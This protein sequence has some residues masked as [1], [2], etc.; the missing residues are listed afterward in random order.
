MFDVVSPPPNNP[1]E[2]LNSPSAQERVPPPPR[3]TVLS[4]SSREERTPQPTKERVYFPSVIDRGKIGTTAAAAVVVVVVVVVYSIVFVHPCPPAL[5][6]PSGYGREVNFFFLFFLQVLTRARR[7]T[8]LSPC[9]LISSRA[10]LFSQCEPTSRNDEKSFTA[11]K[12][13]P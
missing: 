11:P 4:K 3:L 8:L 9:G 13:S 7:V 10:V 2:N 5:S 1:K 12:L 6:V